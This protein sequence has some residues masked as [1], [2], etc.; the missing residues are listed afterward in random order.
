MT[1]DERLTLT[2][3]CGWTTEGSREDVVRETQ[4]HVLKV[5]WTEADE[6]DILEMASPA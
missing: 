4:A 2:C 6:E 3:H 5:H 1:D